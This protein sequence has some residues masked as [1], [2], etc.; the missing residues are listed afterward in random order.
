MTAWA[1][2]ETGPCRSAGCDLSG[3]HWH[4]GE[5]TFRSV[6]DLAPDEVV[7]FDEALGY[8]RPAGGPR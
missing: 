1:H 4:W 5:R 7:P 8:P 3:F 2:V 6:H